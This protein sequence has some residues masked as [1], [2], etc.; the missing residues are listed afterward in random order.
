MTR[1]Q[2]RTLCAALIVGIGG[3]TADKTDDSVGDDS[4]PTDDSAAEVHFSIEGMAIAFGV[5]REP[6]PE[7]ACVKA[8]NPQEGINGGTPE[9]VANT[10][11]G[12]G[13]AFTLTGIPVFDLPPL[14]IIDDCDN[15]PPRVFPTGTPVPPEL[16]TGVTDG[17][18]IRDVQAAS[19]GVETFDGITASLAAA[20]S[21]VDVT[22]D[23]MM[24]G[25]VW[26]I[27]DQSPIV[28]AQVSCSGCTAYYGD[29]NNAD[30][31][32]SAAGVPNTTTAGEALFAIPGAPIG[33]YSATAAG[34]TFESHM[35]GAIPRGALVVALRGTA[36]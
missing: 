21:T 6:A 8:L 26:D 11:V 30:G 15:D 12:P 24:I 4:Q 34:Y 25:F 17:A 16:L 32:F 27:A 13:G 1:P 5:A 2:A 31:L 10:T 22:Q 28:G 14:L 36:Q 20:G 9:E 19:I 18:V 23:G 29:T 35:L 7:G 3:C 33:S